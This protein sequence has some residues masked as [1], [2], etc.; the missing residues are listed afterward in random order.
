MHDLKTPSFKMVA[1]LLCVPTN[2][3]RDELV[4]KV[5]HIIVR[6]K[7]EACD[8]SCHACLVI[9]H[10]GAVFLIESFIMHKIWS[11]RVLCSRGA[12]RSVRAAR[13]CIL[14]STSRF[15]SS[16]DQAQ[17]RDKQ[18]PPKVRAQLGFRGAIA[19][20]A[21][22]SSKR[23]QS[24]HLRSVRASEQGLS[25]SNRLLDLFVNL[26]L[27]RRAWRVQQG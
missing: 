14:R 2:N 1:P 8:F 12:A 10:L 11:C 21:S 16:V 6:K 19:S 26:C 20:T 4:L 5:W 25:S 7:L 23:I 13:V 24:P 9:C 22:V 18:N 17:T 3:V 27:L 15:K